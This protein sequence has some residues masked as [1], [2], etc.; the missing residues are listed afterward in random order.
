ML[1]HHKKATDQSNTTAEAL[2]DS[3]NGMPSGKGHAVLQARIAARLHVMV[4]SFACV[5]K[6]C[7]NFSQD[8]QAWFNR[9]DFPHKKKRSLSPYNMQL[10][11]HFTGVLPEW[12]EHRSEASHLVL[13]LVVCQHLALCWCEG[14]LVSSTHTKIMGK[15]QVHFRL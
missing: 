10:S 14:N 12:F 8:K 7:F 11:I 9:G 6:S 2:H 4:L 5:E 3:V 13:V 1:S 15:Q